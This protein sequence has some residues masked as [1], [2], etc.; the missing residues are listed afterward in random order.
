MLAAEFFSRGTNAQ[1]PRPVFRAWLVASQRVRRISVVPT[2]LP[3]VWA[4]LAMG[5]GVDP[6]AVFQFLKD[7]EVGIP[8]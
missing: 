1:R 5:N 4:A 8:S 7:D 3:V 2:F 6:D